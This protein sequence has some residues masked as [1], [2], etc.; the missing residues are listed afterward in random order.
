MSTLD[1][2][3]MADTAVRLG[4]LSIHHADEAWM[5]LMSRKV[6]AEDFLRFMEGKG[7]LTPFQTSKL[8]KGETDGYFLGGYRMLYKIASGSFGRVYRADDPSSGRVVAIKVLRN[9]WSKD[10]HKIDLFMREA[11]VGMSLRHQ[12]IVE[13]L[14]VNQ[15]KTTNQ[16]YI[17]MEFVEGGNLRDLLA[18]RKKLQ[19]L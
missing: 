11:K 7:Y 15:E 2:G 8:L 16:Y 10:A 18:M 5:E 19:V 3:A 14:A 6:P 4:L 12:N 9:K 1:A 17:V 13:I